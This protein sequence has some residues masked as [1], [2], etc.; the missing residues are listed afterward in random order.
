MA[1]HKGLYNFS[2]GELA[3]ELLGRVDIQPYSAGLKRA[4]NVIVR[5]YGGITMRPG[6]H[7]VAPFYDE[8][9]DG[10][11]IPF[12]FD[13]GKSGQNYALEMS[14]AYM[15]PAAGG[16]LVVEELLTV[17]GIT[18]ASAAV[19]HINFHAYVVGDDW[20]VSGVLGMV[21]VNNQIWRITG[22]VDANHFTINANSATWGVFTGDGAGGITR[23]AAP[24]PP[25]APPVVPPPVEPDPPPDIIGGGGD[26]GFYIP[27]DRW[28]F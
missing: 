12:Q 16:G 14:Q 15:R 17:Q 9:E 27:D 18:N 11:L 10:R 25:P 22:I 7:F 4:R 24:V 3:P 19:V 28:Y 21:E 20:A 1:Y 6:L 13:E 5:K 2:K 26:D 8:T 23:I